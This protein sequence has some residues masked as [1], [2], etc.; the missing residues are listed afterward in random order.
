LE[1]L[2]EIELELTKLED[3]ESKISELELANML[4]NILEKLLEESE[5]L[6]IFELEE[7][8]DEAGRLVLELESWEELELIDNC[9]L[10]CSDSEEATRL[11]EIRIEE[12]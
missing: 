11:L 6:R 3:D 5:L 1:E 2:L 9:E 12:A 10:L 8:T 7:T 4:D